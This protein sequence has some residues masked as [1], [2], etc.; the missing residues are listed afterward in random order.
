MAINVINYFRNSPQMKIRDD[1]IAYPAPGYFPFALLPSSKRWLFW[2]IQQ[3]DKIRT[4]NAVVDVSGP[5]GSIPVNVCYKGYT[6]FGPIVV[7]EVVIPPLTKDETYTVTISGLT[8]V[9][10]LETVA[11]DVIVFNA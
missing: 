5:D 8:G 10:S 2:P 11:Y 1:F 7:F 3:Q 9:P 6:Q 4:S